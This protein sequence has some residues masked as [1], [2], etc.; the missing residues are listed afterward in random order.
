MAVLA[1]TRLKIGAD[2]LADRA[3]PGSLLAVARR[4]VEQGD[5]QGLFLFGHDLASML[6]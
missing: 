5:A 1:A 6:V 2:V 4:G 3:V